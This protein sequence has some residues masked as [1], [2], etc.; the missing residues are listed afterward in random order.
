MRWRTP[1]E[2]TPGE[3]STLFDRL[4]QCLYVNTFRLRF[5]STFFVS[6][7]APAV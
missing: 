3:T 1:G 5:A 7:R 4:N 6:L 2:G